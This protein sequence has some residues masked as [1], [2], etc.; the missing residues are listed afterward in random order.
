M[1][2]PPVSITRCAQPGVPV[3]GRP[4]GA[5]TSVARTVAV[6]ATVPWVDSADTAMAAARPA[7]AVGEAEPGR[8]L[9][10]HQGDAAPGGGEPDRDRDVPA[11]CQHRVRPELPHRPARLEDA[12]GI[13]RH[14]LGSFAGVPG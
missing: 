8:L 10:H 4:A 1:T 12:D 2:D 5:C 13:P 11:G 7:R 6:R 14:S 9:V 3:P